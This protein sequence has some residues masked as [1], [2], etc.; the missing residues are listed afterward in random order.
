M[1]ADAI[2]LWSTVSYPS[3]HDYRGRI[4]LKVKM[5]QTSKSSGR[6]IFCIVRLDLHINQMT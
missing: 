5:K 4:M 2:T 1:F 3:M 6:C